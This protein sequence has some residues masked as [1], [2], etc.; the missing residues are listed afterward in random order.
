MVEIFLN[1][2]STRTTTIFCLLFSLFCF[3][4]TRFLTRSSTGAGSKMFFCRVY[5]LVDGITDVPRIKPCTSEVNV[6]SWWEWL[7]EG[8]LEFNLVS[9]DIFLKIKQK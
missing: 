6:Q 7:E 1:K 3:R 8:N 4:D 9:L 2:T 5:L